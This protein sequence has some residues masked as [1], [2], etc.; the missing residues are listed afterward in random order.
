MITVDA[1]ARNALDRAITQAVASGQ[2]KDLVGRLSTLE[3]LDA[4]VVVFERD[5]HVAFVVLK[6]VNRTWHALIEGFLVRWQRGR[7]ERNR[8]AA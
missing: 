3:A 1:S 2:L 4:Q 7:H 6:R 8:A 5:G